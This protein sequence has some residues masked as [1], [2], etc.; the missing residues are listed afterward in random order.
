MLKC[1]K[2]ILTTVK[3]LDLGRLPFVYVLR[4]SQGCKNEQPWL[5]EEVNPAR[6]KWESR[7]WCRIK[8]LLLQHRAQRKVQSA[9]KLI[10]HF[11][12]CSSLM[13]A[14]KHW[15]YSLSNSRVLLCTFVWELLQKNASTHIKEIFG[16]DH[17]LSI[18]AVQSK[19]MQCNFLNFFA[20]KTDYQIKLPP[21]EKS[22][23]Y[24]DSEMKDLHT[25]PEIINFSFLI[26]LF[27]FLAK[28]MFYIWRSR[29]MMV[30]MP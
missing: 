23:W 10:G 27:V 16:S 6:V 28:I 2:M 24:L 19:W 30:M 8:L 3:A 29:L 1:L 9:Q 21:S 14:Q 25:G 20:C 26:K 15:D 4:K 13:S 17:S 11:L 5:S 18:L 12:D 22:R 7:F